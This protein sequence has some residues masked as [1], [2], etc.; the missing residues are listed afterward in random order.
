MFLEPALELFGCERPERH[1]K[2]QIERE[3]GTSIQIVPAFIQFY[4][5]LFSLQS[6]A[7]S[8]HQNSEEHD[9]TIIDDYQIML[10]HALTVKLD[11]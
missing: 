5:D 7:S 8:K 1:W 3:A 2:T 9:Q 11:K 4:S 10:G 6:D